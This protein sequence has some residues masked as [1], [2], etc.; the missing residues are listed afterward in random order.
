[1][2]MGEYCGKPH[3]SPNVF[4][5]LKK[6]TCQYIFI[7]L[8]AAR[9]VLARLYGRQGRFEKRSRR[10]GEFEQYTASPQS[11]MRLQAQGSSGTR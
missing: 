2:K 5:A 10:S 3:Y 1:M 9:V 6:Y 7:K 11:D 8:P 4:V